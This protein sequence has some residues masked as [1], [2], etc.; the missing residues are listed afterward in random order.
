MYR[1]I[2]SSLIIALLGLGC[3]T[4]MKIKDNMTDSVTIENLT[5][6]PEGDL[7]AATTSAPDTDTTHY[8]NKTR[9]LTIK[10]WHVKS[11]EEQHSQVVNHPIDKMFFSPDGQSLALMYDLEHSRFTSKTRHGSIWHITHNELLEKQSYMPNYLGPESIIAVSPN[12]RFTAEPDQKDR[13][14]LWENIAGKISDV[15]QFEDI[16]RIHAMRFSSD[17]KR[18]I[19]IGGYLDRYQNHTQMMYFD[20]S[21]KREKVVLETN[22]TFISFQSHHHRLITQKDKIIEIWD[23]FNQALIHKIDFIGDIKHIQLSDDGRFMAAITHSNLIL[24]SKT[25]PI[26]ME[27]RNIVAI[28]DLK[29]GLPLHVL[30]EGTRSVTSLAMSSDNKTLA[31]GDSKGVI[32]LWNMLN[33]KMIKRI[34]VTAKTQI[35]KE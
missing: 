2:I 23:T 17:S 29:T 13:I 20:I 4:S 28:W 16:E 22:S 8:R 18:L 7:L 24:I 12:N 14:R 27:N 6:T 21:D 1:T 5:F 31:T 25:T 35:V 19:V 32:R 15:Y 30:S 26:K 10:L 9:P 11:G 34:A 3:Q 33:G